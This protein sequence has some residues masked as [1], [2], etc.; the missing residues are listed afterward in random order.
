MSRRKFTPK[1]KLKVVLDALKD[2]HTLAELA[3]KYEL[4]AQ[5][6]SNWKSDFLKE[7]EGVFTKKIKSK[8]TQEEEEKDKLLKT[9]GSL[10]VENDFLKEVLR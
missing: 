1:F 2:R 4:H 5:Q 8:K 9:I 10:K 3:D 6:I 7:A